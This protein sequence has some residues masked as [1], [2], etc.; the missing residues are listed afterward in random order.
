MKVVNEMKTKRNTKTWVWR[1]I[2]IILVLVFLVSAGMVTKMLIQGKMEDDA[3]AAWAESVEKTTPKT[4]HKAEKE[5]NKS[6]DANSYTKYYLLHEQNPNFVGWLTMDNTAVNYPVMYTPDEPEYYL[7]RAFDGSYAV[8]GTPFIG[9]G[10]T[11][12]SDCFIIYG[13]NMDNGTMFGTLDHYQ[14]PTFFKANPRFTFTTL[15]E[16]R[17]YEVFAAV[18]TQL[19]YDHEEGFRY[20]QSCGDLTEEKFNTLITWLK[21][22]ASYESG[23]IPNYGEQIVM[24]STCSYHTDN[25]RFIVAARLVNEEK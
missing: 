7:R 9:T 1:S 10:A 14:D 23:I 17:T 20:Y 12:D 2:N 24:L 4:I 13:H 15:T 8:S 22:H 11:I 21:N 6:V 5:E 16:K 25:G 18:S 19:L 3:F